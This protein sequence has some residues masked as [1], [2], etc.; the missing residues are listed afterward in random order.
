MRFI[1]RAAISL[2]PI[3]PDQVYPL[4]L[5][6]RLSGLSTCALREAQRNGLRT[7]K[8]GRQR[9]IMGR[10]WHEYLAALEGSAK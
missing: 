6:Q 4:A 10:D 7:K 8:V 5:F 2:G 3:C 9:F 1:E